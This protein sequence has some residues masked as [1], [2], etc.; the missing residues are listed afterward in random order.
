MPEEDNPFRALGAD[1]KVKKEIDQ[2]ALVECVSVMNE[3]VRWAMMDARRVISHPDITWHDGEQP[4]IRVAA[5]HE[6]LPP[7]TIRP[8]NLPARAMR[9]ELSY[10][11]KGQILEVTQFIHGAERYH[12]FQ[13][14]NVSRDLIV[15]EISDF[16][17]QT[18]GV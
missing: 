16:I 5:Q 3:V 15:K 10:A 1:V 17:K 9:N 7:G 11:C 4:S 2:R 13:I 12:E 8:P 6:S 14:K 18:L